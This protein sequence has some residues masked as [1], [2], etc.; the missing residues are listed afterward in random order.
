MVSVPVL[1]N[2]MVSIRPAISRLGASLN[3]TP[4]RA[5]VPMPAMMAAGVANPSAHGQAMTSTETALIN[6]SSKLPNI[7]QFPNNTTSAMP[8]TTGT[9]TP[10]TLSAKRAMSAFVPCASSSA[11]TMSPSAVSPP[12]AVARYSN[13]PSTTALPARTP[14]PAV[15]AS[16]ALSP[17]RCASSVKPAPVVTTPSTPMRS[18]TRASRTS[19]TLMSLI[20]TALH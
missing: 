2:T 9:K 1:S 6:A 14:S 5:A 17:V 12:V 19:P 7:A 16:A 13:P 15:L 20:L 18:P 8:T 4:Y 10:A 11:R 3:R